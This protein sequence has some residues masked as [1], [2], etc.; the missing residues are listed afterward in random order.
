MFDQR[1]SLRARRRLAT[2]AE[3]LALCGLMLSLVAAGGRL[4]I[5]KQFGLVYLILNVIEVQKLVEKH[6]RD[7]G[8]DIAVEYV[9][10]FSG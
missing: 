4:R 8:L 9:R 5:A 10:L 7:A 6:G 1:W 2:Q 3:S